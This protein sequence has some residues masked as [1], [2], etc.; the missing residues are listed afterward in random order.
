MTNERTDKPAIK[1]DRAIEIAR[2][3]AQKVYRDLSSDYYASAALAADGWHVQFQLKDIK[4]NGGGPYYLIDAQS[5]AI[6][7]KRY[8]Q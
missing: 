2:D 1:I 6:C 3:D 7:A 4:V 8:E 5:G